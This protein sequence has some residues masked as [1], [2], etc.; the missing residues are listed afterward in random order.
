MKNRWNGGEP[1]N[2]LSL[3][4]VKTS[5]TVS[6]FILYTKNCQHKTQPW[7]PVP[8]L[9]LSNG[10]RFFFAEQREPLLSDNV[11][12]FFHIQI[13]Q[14]LSLPDRQ[15]GGGTCGFAQGDADGHNPKIG[16]CQM[17]TADIPPRQQE[18]LLIVLFFTINFFFRFMCF[19]QI[20]W[21]L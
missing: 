11:L 16:M 8:M 7:T 2:L 10:Y 4:S 12:D 1:K 21:C 15:S 6:D 5:F 20:G 19:V 17:G 9:I 3:I 18:S 14:F 13:P